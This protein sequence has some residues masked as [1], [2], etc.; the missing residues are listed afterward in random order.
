MRWGAYRFVA[1]ATIVALLAVGIAA[2]GD[3]EATTDA[4][5]TPTTTGEATGASNGQ[6]PKEKAGSRG[7]DEGEEEK[8]AGGVNGSAA[9]VEPV[10][11]S[12]SGGGSGQ[13]RVKGGDNSIQ[14]WGEEDEGELAAAAE[15]VH[16]FY[17]ARAN[18]D[19]T[20]ACSYLAKSMVEK[21]AQFASQSGQARKLDCPAILEALTRPLPADLR[22]EST[23]VDAGS[24]RVGEESSFLIYRGADRIVY[25]M[26]LEN[27]DGAWKLTLIA[28]T[29]L[30]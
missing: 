9:E 14:S 16:G 11:L 2:C 30:G 13:F 5:S 4:A 29:A 6:S 23:I 24:L 26:P 17:V 18:L 7:H 8:R 15:A 20:A 21:L 19:W 22:R 10:P 3:D 27:E 28:P 12:V 25:A 1:V